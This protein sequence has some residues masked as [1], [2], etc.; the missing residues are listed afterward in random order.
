LEIGKKLCKDI[1]FF[2]SVDGKLGEANL[3]IDEIKYIYNSN[4]GRNF[5]VICKSAALILKKAYERVDIKAKLVESNNTFAKI[6][7]DDDF[8]ISHWWL[9]VYDEND[10]YFVTLNPDLPY[11]Q[12]NMATKH[13]GTNISYKKEY[14][15][16]LIQVYKGEEIKHSVISED[17]LKKIDIAIGY[18]KKYYKYNDKFQNDNNWFLQYDNASLYMLRDALLN[19]KLFYDLEKEQTD[20]FKNLFN[21]E[22]ENNR[23]ISLLDDDI[24]SLSNKDWDIWIK[25]MCKQVLNRIEETLGYKVDVLP[26]LESAYWNFQSWLFNLCVQIQFDLFKKFDNNNSDDFKNL[27]ID[28]E[29]FKYNKWSRKLK[30]IF[31]LGKI[32]SEHDNILVILD[33]TNAL[34]NCI[35][36]DEKKKH[37]SDLFSSLTY[38]FIDPTHLYENNL[39]ENGYL[40]NSYIA[41][42]FDKLFRYIFS[43][44]ELITNFNKMEYGEQSIVI[45][46]VLDLMFPEVTYN[47]SFMLE[48]YNNDFNAL[49]NRIQI[50]TIKDK[51]DGKYSILFN[52][53]GNNAS[54]DYYFLYNP[55]TNEFSVSNVLDIY[56]DYIIVSNRM[57]NRTSVEDLEKLDNV[58]NRT[59]K[60]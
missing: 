57:K 58:G 53:L 11:I 49:F 52:V 47:N 4:I 41:N 31:N 14:N 45:K 27:E 30:N 19:N 46:E 44:N 55:K 32:N 23:K 54:G 24:N 2:F 50:Y 39:D 17:E 1:D 43:C 51:N 60:K 5:N 9:A 25:L 35:Q 15:G 7:D 40:S 16:N 13:F 26:D 8:L 29:N 18:I 6:S 34:V 3:S 37:L 36:K 10:A 22:G 28:V 21:F 12:M 33:K 38:H 48:D 56:N 20:F 42:K 59:I